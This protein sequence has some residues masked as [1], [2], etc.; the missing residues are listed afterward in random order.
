MSS[1]ADC[2]VEVTW[3][4]QVEN[5]CNYSVVPSDNFSVEICYLTNSG[6]V[7]QELFVS[8]SSGASGLV[9]F[10]EQ[11]TTFMLRGRGISNAYGMSNYSDWFGPFIAYTS[12]ESLPPS[13]LSVV[14][15][16]PKSLSMSWV[17]PRGPSASCYSLRQFEVE[18]V[19]EGTLSPIAANISN[20]STVLTGLSENSYYS[21]RVRGF[22]FAVALDGSFLD[23]GLSSPYS[24]NFMMYTLPR[25]ELICTLRRP[26]HKCL[27]AVKYMH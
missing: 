17:E 10:V 14:A 7:L 22:L 27:L 18:C 26:C 6:L 11:N 12:L 24:E 16:Q 2:M 4:H 9:R 25:G 13:V 3:T 20:T 19:E 5:T 15:S 8:P 21:C 23:L 1:S